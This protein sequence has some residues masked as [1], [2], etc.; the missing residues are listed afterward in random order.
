MGRF[1]AFAP[2]HAPQARINILE[3]IRLKTAR[4][5]G[6]A[7]LIAQSLVAPAELA[8]ET[9]TGLHFRELAALLLTAT[10]LHVCYTSRRKSLAGGWTFFTQQHDSLGACLKTMAGDPPRFHWGHQAIAPNK[11]ALQK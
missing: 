1:E 10:I 5:F 8:R 4:E 7:Q 2:C 9:T 6:D 11:T 3:T